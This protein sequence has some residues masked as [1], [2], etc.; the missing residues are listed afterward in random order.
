[1]AEFNKPRPSYINPAVSLS[2]SDFIRA[3]DAATWQ[4]RVLVAEIARKLDIDPD[5]IVADAIEADRAQH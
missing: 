5:K 1:M 3:V 4:T 2:A